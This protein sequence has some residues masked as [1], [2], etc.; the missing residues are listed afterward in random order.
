MEDKSAQEHGE[1]DPG[2][3]EPVNAFSHG[4]PSVHENE[5]CTRKEQ[6]EQGKGECQQ[7]D[8]RHGN[9]H[10]ARLAG[11]WCL[12]TFCHDVILR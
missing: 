5:R 7:V 10:I 9:A 3:E 1:C 6:R 2:P 11:D 12:G 8:A 4:A